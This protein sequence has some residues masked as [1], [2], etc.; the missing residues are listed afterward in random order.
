MVE[1]TYVDPKD[2]QLTSGHPSL[3]S[4]LEKGYESGN[5]NPLWSSHERQPE[6][7]SDDELPTGADEAKLDESQVKQMGDAIIAAHPEVL[8]AWRPPAGLS[9]LSEI[10]A[11]ARTDELCVKS[12]VIGRR[13]S[14]MKEKGKE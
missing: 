10:R 14:R 6:M 7:N 8:K 11:L 3:D 1:S 13:C 2:P 12:Y 5:E 9:Q 4:T